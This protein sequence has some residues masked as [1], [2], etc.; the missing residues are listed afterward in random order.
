MRTEYPDAPDKLLK[1]LAEKRLSGKMLDREREETTQKQ[2]EADAAKKRE[3][4]P[5]LAFAARYPDRA[6]LAPEEVKLVQAGR[7]PIE[8]R[9]EHEKSAT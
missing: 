5:W 6:E 9:L 1:E 4:E 8:A 7:T 2:L 3:L